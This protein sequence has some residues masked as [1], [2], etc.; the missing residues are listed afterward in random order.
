MNVNIGLNLCQPSAP[1][2]SG[3]TTSWQGYRLRT[4]LLATTYI[5]RDATGRVSLAFDWRQYPKKSNR[6]STLAP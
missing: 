1:E 2:D 3:M 4:V 6:K 5:T